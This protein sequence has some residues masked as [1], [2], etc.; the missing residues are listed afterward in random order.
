MVR[1]PRKRAKRRSQKQSKNPRAA[2][3]LLPPAHLAHRRQIADGTAPIRSEP[4][5]GQGLTLCAIMVF[6]MGQLPLSQF[7]LQRSCFR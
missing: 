1:T 5:S 7:P 2:V 4:V 6:S 3:D